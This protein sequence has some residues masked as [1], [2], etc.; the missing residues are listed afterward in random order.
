MGRPKEGREPLAEPGLQ[1]VVA[2]DDQIGAGERGHGR[3]CHELALETLAIQD[4]ERTLRARDEGHE[5]IGIA[6]PLEPHALRHAVEPGGLAA[7]REG[8][9]V[10]IEGVDDPTR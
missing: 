4:H 7:D 5:P 6:A 10:E 3:G 9:L 8:L 2:L 1:E